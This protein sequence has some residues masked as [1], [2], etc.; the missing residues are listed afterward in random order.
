MNA[1]T[2][3]LDSEKTAPRAP[4]AGLAP[5]LERRRLRVYLLQML[6]DIALLIGTCALVAF[7]YAG[8]GVVLPALLPAQLLLPLFLTIAWHN[9]TYSLHSLTDWRSSSL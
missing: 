5:S 3:V 2:V 6:I 4:A 1:P 9:G 7:V 8:K